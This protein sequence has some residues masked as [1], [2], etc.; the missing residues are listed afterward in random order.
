MEGKMPHMFEDGEI[1]DDENH[2]FVKD[3]EYYVYQEGEYI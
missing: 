1:Y 2:Y 3:G